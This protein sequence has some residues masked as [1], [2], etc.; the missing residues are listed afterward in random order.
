MFKDD[1]QLRYAM[2]ILT[3]IFIIIQFDII[4]IQFRNPAS[5][6]DYGMLDLRE[7][8]HVATSCNNS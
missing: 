1:P 8:I 7:E 2:S 6:A 5:L 3:S 4:T